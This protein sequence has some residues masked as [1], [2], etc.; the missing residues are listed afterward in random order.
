MSSDLGADLAGYPIIRLDH[1]SLLDDS[2]LARACLDVSELM[3]S[4]RQSEEPSSKIVFYLQKQFDVM[5]NEEGKRAAALRVSNLLSGIEDA[6]NPTVP[7]N[8]LKVDVPS[9][10][11]PVTVVES[12]RQSTSAPATLS[13]AKGD[14]DIECSPYTPLKDRHVKATCHHSIEDVDIKNVSTNEGQ[15]SSET[16]ALDSLDAYQSVMNRDKKMHENDKLI[17]LQRQKRIVNEKFGSTFVVEST[18]K[19]VRFFPTKKSKEESPE[20]AFAREK[21]NRY[22]STTAIT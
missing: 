15:T 11:R 3:I 2:T 21:D 19:K 4:L 18:H 14:V 16:T 17:R 5:K 13:V 1:I 20:A 12:I 6:L 8:P 9:T 7:S 22:I 10:P